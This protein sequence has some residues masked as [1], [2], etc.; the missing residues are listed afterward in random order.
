M[1]GIWLGAWDG[2][3]GGPLA[4]SAQASARIRVLR[5]HADFASFRFI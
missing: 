2:S 3:T 1:A 4:G 5:G